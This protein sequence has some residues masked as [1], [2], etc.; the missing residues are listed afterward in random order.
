MN[1]IKANDEQAA[2]ALQYLM[3]KEKLAKAVKRMEK[4]KQS[5]GGDDTKNG[6]RGGIV[7]GIN[8][9]LH[10]LAEEGLADESNLF[11]ESI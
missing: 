8:N 7:G 6:F 2:E 9:A 1:W 5:Y 3:M 4:I 10:C 11:K